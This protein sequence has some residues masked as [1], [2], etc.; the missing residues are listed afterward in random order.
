MALLERAIA[1]DPQHPGANHFYIHAVEASKEP[2]RAMA[3]ADRLRDL[4]P[5][6]G[7]L[8]HMPAHVFLRTGRYWDAVLANRRA[9]PPGSRRLKRLGDSQRTFK[10]RFRMSERG[11][12]VRLRARVRLQAITWMA[13]AL[14]RLAFSAGTAL[15]LGIGVA[16]LYRRVLAAACLLRVHGRAPPDAPGEPG[17]TLRRADFRARQGAADRRCDRLHLARRLPARSAR[18]T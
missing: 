3:S 1:L 17:A 13:M 2:Q 11:R 10:T 12:Y 4:V 16:V 6:A 7:H 18:A 8:V 5:G 14:S 9:H 15:G